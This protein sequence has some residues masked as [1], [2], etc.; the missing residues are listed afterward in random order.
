MTCVVVKVVIIIKTT[1]EVTSKREG[2][3]EKETLPYCEVQQQEWSQK[4]KE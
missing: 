4:Q 1:P 3:R 2:E